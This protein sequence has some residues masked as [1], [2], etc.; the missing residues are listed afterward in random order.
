MRQLISIGIF[1]AVCGC[2]D[3]K[4]PSPSAST[5]SSRPTPDSGSMALTRAPAS[6][7]S[8]RVGARSIVLFPVDSFPELPS[9]LASRLKNRGCLV[10]QMDEAGDRSN[11]LHGEFWARGDSGWATMCELGKNVGILVFHSDSL[12]NPDSLGWYPESLYAA[13]RVQ[14]DGSY[15]LL[16]TRQISVFGAAEARGRC[17]IPP[18]TPVHD[19]IIDWNYQTLVGAHFHDHEGWQLCAGWGEDDD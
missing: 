5:D 15:R 11:V 18:A 9:W 2:A 12:V 6:A 19:G 3:G 7:G 8:P 17:L 10:P 16:W 1:I 13:H 4:A 14:P